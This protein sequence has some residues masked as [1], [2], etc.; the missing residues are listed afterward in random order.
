MPLGPYQGTGLGPG[1]GAPAYSAEHDLQGM[2]YGSPHHCLF[3]THALIDGASRDA[4]N[5][6]NTTVLRPGLIMAQVTATQKWKPFDNTEDD[7]TEIPRGILTLLGLNTQLDG[8][9]TDRFLATIM[10]GGNVNPEALCI[11]ATTAYGLPTTGAGL[12]VR[13]A[14]M[15]SFR[16][17]DDF[18]GLVPF[19][20]DDRTFA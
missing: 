13:K 3:L 17:S 10:V 20:L 19:P 12:A 5:T 11:A 6:D 9:D 7:G 8:S 1:M 16:M 4:G 2:I 15:L 14:F 18:Q